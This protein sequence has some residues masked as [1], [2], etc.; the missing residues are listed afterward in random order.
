MMVDLLVVTNFKP[1]DDVIKEGSEGDSMYIVAGGDT[2]ECASM[3]VSLSAAGERL[4]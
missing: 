4:Y 3:C 2:A 1:G